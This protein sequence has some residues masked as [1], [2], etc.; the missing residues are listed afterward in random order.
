[1]G[2]SSPEKLSGRLRPVL[3]G[4]LIL[5][6]GC[7][8]NQP[9]PPSLEELNNSDRPKSLLAR[10]KVVQPPGP[11]PFE[12]KLEPVARGL[13]DE[14][15]LY[16]LV[17]EKAP[18][19][20]AISALVHD[21]DLNLS[22]ESEIDISRPVTVRLKR[23]TLRE[24]LDMVVTKGAGYAWKLEGDRLALKR[25]E[26]RIYH[27]NY[28]DMPGATEIEVGGDMLASGVDDSGVTGK[29]QIKATRKSD[30]TDLWK[31]LGEA[32]EGLKS[33]EGAL[34]FNRQ[35]GI[36]FM[37]DTPRRVDA[38]IRFLDSLAASL[39]RQVLIEA[40]ILEV[41]LS[42]EAKYGIDW[43]SAEIEFTSSSDIF[44]D[45]MN[46][47]V[48]SGGA[49]VLSD[50]SRFDAVLDFLKTQGEVSI[51][52]NPNLT[53]MNGQSAIMTVGSQ[54]PYGDVSGVDRDPETGVITFG[55]AIKRTILGLQ[56]GITPQISEDGLVILHI[57]PTITRIQGQE[58]VELPTSTTTT[59]SI[60]N[61]IIDLQE[62]ATFVRVREG[63][64]I[65]LAGLISQIKTLT[66]TGLP[67]LGDIPLLG[68]F[69]KH[70]EETTENKELVILI[71]PYV[72][73]TF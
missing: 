71:T 12:E 60:S 53:V 10:E 23:V 33:P 57:V 13:A 56:L 64:A 3:L 19:G 22:V 44:P 27:L 55:T 9:R 37:A 17:F 38:M 6:A 31:G 16:S 15:R 5:L 61:P 48:N 20:D 4:L 1:M 59:Q 8:L 73:N 43:S 62:L 47:S 72:K 46:L 11:P 35:S 34:R 29:F 49:L 30:H 42:D 51:L 25:F 67:L 32:L 26:E 65:V 66:H 54:F 28:L 70:M 58:E 68:Q 41:S 36:I 52:S 45:S 21:T 7:A 69:F 40:K 39:N 50:Q 18:L 24:A 63:N 2:Y 14:T